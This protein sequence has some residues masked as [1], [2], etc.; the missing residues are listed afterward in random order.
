M[1]DG[2]YREA[3]GIAIRRLETSD[4]F[5]SEVRT[6]L[7]RFPEDIVSRVVAELTQRGFLN[8]GRTLSGVV[9]RNQGRRA[10]GDALLTERLARKGIDEAS[11]QDAL[12]D[13]LPEPERIREILIRKYQPTDDPAKAGRFL[14]SRG[15]S[16]D[17]IES[18]LADY[19]TSREDA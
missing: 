15:F 8:D 11:V 5:E 1:E 6:A 19:F 3:L 2:A 18:A 16:E 4:R 9:A 7:R 12:I 13:A 10:V 17:A 14:Y